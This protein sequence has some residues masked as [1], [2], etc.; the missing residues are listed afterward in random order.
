MFIFVLSFPVSNSLCQLVAEVREGTKCYKSTLHRSLGVAAASRCDGGT[1]REK[2]SRQSLLLHRLLTAAVGVL[3]TLQEH[4]WSRDATRHSRPRFATADNSI[5]SI[6][7]AWLCS[8]I[9]RQLALRPTVSASAHS[10][11]WRWLTEE[12]GQNFPT[13][14]D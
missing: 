8:L 1:K 4:C 7:V 11:P 14:F 12:D 10:K 3:R 13:Y 2:V 5:N 6:L 9:N